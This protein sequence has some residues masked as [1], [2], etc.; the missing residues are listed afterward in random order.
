MENTIQ[1]IRT[2]LLYPHPQNPRKDVGDVSELADSIKAQGIKQNLL[3]TPTLDGSYR[4]VIGHRRLAAAKIAGLTEVPCVVQDLSEREQLELMIVENSQRS[5]LKPIEEA[6]AYQGLLDLGMTRGEIAEKTGRSKSYVGKRVKIASIPAEARGM[7]DDFS[8]L[9]L[10]DLE[11]LAEFA[12][13]PDV[14][15]RLAQAAGT[16]NWNYELNSAREDRRDREWNEQAHAEIR[17]RGLKTLPESVKVPENSWEGIPGYHEVEFF[18]RNN[19]TFKEQWEGFLANGGDPDAFIVE[20]SDRLFDV[21]LEGDSEATRSRKEWQEKE[22]KENA[23]R[24]A[25]EKPIKEFDRNIRE[26][27]YTWIHNHL[28]VKTSEPQRDALERLSMHLL[29]GDS[30]YSISAVGGDVNWEDQLIYAYNRMT[31]EPLPVTEKDTKQNVYHL[32]TEENLNEL[33]LRQSAAPHH[34]NMLLCFAMCEASISWQTWQN[35]S[36]NP[37]INDYYTTLK[38]LGYP[39]SDVE[40]EALAGGFEDKEES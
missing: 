34:E 16:N 30:S 9:S 32:T 36:H 27:R 17:G 6:D 29:M 1:M 37:I 14:Q 7:A 28:P 10:S 11:A 2:D 15:L 26:L 25:Q 22:R 20:R 24:K 21:E 39:I 8:Q 12:D 35:I 18:S 13:D 5:D 19:G 4:V 33:T 23:K 31:K 3:V 40:K 38:T